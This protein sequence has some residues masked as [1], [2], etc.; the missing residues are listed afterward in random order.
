MA[1]EKALSQS[2]AEELKKDQEHPGKIPGEGAGPAEASGGGS[3]DPDS[4][5]V[6][7]GPSGGA[8]TGGGVSG[9]SE[10]TGDGPS[11]GA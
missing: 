2:E 1:D 7:D 11:G 5:A 6:G 9:D 3:S 4:A 8:P 10:P